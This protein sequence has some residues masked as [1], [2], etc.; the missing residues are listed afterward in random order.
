MP[1]I[2]EQRPD[3]TE[4]NYFVPLLLSVCMLMVPH[5]LRAQDTI[6]PQTDL[7]DK[8]R[9]WFHKPAKPSEPTLEQGKLY[10]AFLP[11]IGYTPANGFL[12]GIG[13]S[14]S[15]LLGDSKNTSISSA[16]ANLNITSKEQLLLN[17]RS[18]IFSQSNE[19]NFQGDYRL[20]FFSQP[21]YGLGIYFKDR[22][23][24]SLGD[25]S[26]DLPVTEQP[27]RFNYIRLYQTANKK[28]APSLYLGL[29]YHLD[30]HFRISDILLDTTSTE[31]TLTDHYVYS[32]T[33]RFPQKKYF[34]SGLV[35]NIISDNRD[36]PI[37]SRSGHYANM[38]LRIN[39]TW[40][41]STEGSTRLFLEYRRF[42]SLSRTKPQKV[43]SFW[44]WHSYLLGGEQPYLSL[45]S[46]TWDTYNRS[47]RGYIQGR[48][49][50]ENFAYAE[51]EYR[52]PITQNGLLSGVAFLNVCSASDESTRQPV[53]LKFAPGYGG[54]L[55]I[56][57]DKRTRTN[58]SI[59][60]GRGRNGSSGVYFNLQ[61]AF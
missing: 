8:F 4:R 14:A 3:M 16:L 12:A 40:L 31:K 21:T 55:R 13:T 34:T 50:G 42:I 36:H 23:A 35:F 52:F 41:G 60:Y 39:G 5:A 45:P 1:A 30:Y 57:I 53:L 2:P 32:L 25:S 20:L 33:N 38:S 10:T 7:M 27:M 18:N 56:S 47:G 9:E 28:V 6:S 26:Y 51:S 44:T 43:L 29:G 49:R 37:S 22:P 58:L 19:W 15:M 24:L 61:E 59:D 11:I 54:G 46:I 48:F 17:L